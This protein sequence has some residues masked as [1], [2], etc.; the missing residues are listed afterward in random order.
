MNRGGIRTFRF[1]PLKSILNIGRFATGSGAG[2][3]APLM[4]HHGLATRGGHGDV[5]DLPGWPLHRVLVLD[6]PFRERPCGHVPA[7]HVHP[8]LPARSMD[9]LGGIFR[10]RLRPY[11][12]VRS[13]A[14]ASS[15]ISSLSVLRACG[16]LTG[17][18]VAESES[19]K[20]PLLA[21]PSRPFALTSMTLKVRLLG[22][23]KTSAG[24]ALR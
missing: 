22:R 23:V 11:E 21:L 14:L 15:S 6:G 1:P 8:G 20:L 17:R 7:V 3:E 18:T 12:R 10:G 4:A 2:N 24:P 5:L 19:E 9:V 13:T 16:C